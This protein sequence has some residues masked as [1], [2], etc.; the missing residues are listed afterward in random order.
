MNTPSFGSARDLDRHVA[1]LRASTPASMLDR[2]PELKGHWILKVHEGDIVK[3]DYGRILNPLVDVLDGYN[4]VTT[5]GKGTI[6]DRLYALGSI[7]AVT[8]IGV[9][10]DNTAA[11]VGNTTLTAVDYGPA[12]FDSLPTRASLVVTSQQTYSTAQGNITWAEIAEF[13]A[14]NAMLNRI[15]PIGPYTKTS[16]NSIIAVLQLTQS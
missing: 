13:T 3:D 2:V 12:A 6:L 16:A 15:A 1:E 8:K 4:L 9:G 5:V 11:A 14:A 10:T 7:G